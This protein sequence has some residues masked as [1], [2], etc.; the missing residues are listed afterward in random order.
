METPELEN[1]GEILLHSE[2][3]IPVEAEKMFSSSSKYAKRQEKSSSENPEVVVFTKPMPMEDEIQQ[4]S[5]S[6]NCTNSFFGPQLF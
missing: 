4:F 2:E 3:N 6:D 1:E 5:A